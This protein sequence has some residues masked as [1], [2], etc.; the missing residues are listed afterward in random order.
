M[1]TKTVT[2]SA[3]ISC[4]VAVYVEVPDTETMSDPE[5]VAK[6]Q[7]FADA[8]K[9]TKFRLDPCDIDFM[10]SDWAQLT[11]SDLES[12]DN[13]IDVMHGG[14]RDTLPLSINERMHDA[15][16][17]LDNL[18]GSWLKSL[19]YRLTEKDTEFL[20]RMLLAMALNNASGT[21]SLLPAE[22]EFVESTGLMVERLLQSI[23][24]TV[25]LEEDGE[26]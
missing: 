8:G 12:I 7:E 26:L 2:F 22:C 17:M 10:E 23:T 24:P 11:T 3:T 6:A 5:V 4:P 20:K 16:S 25:G 14:F 19:E 15:Y 21:R 13:T 9:N 1:T 18:I